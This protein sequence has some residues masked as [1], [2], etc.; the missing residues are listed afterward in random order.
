MGNYCCFGRLR[1][2][3]E[4]LES[5]E[6]QVL[7]TVASYAPIS[8]ALGLDEPENDIYRFDLAH[9]KGD[10]AEIVSLC[11]SSQAIDPF[12]CQ[13]HQW[14]E[15]PTTV[16]AL[17]ATQLAI[18]ASDEKNPEYKDAIR[19]ASGIPMLVKLLKSDEVDR[20]H[21]AIVAL[22]FLSVGNHE[23]CI[24]MYNAGAMPDLIRGM[25][26]SITGMSG[27]CAHTCRNIYQLGALL[28]FGFNN[29][30]LDMDYRRFFV[31][32]GGLKDLINLLSSSDDDDSETRATQLEAIYHLEDFI[33]DGVEEIPE[34][35]S[36]VKASGALSKL[37]LL[38]KSNDE[39]LRKA[40]K[41]MSV[42]LAD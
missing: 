17:A 13:I 22:A 34:F 35:V 19:K 1:E 2:Y 41:G 29:F 4:K 15:N 8:N 24:E 6:A 36:L 30:I 21:A 5:I 23:N 37:K 3:Q 18:Y 20:Y 7:D 40:A 32:C 28:Y 39:D 27:A 9:D 42:R 25:R 12:T 33:M 10:I 16:G 31:K 38:E 26:S 11:E 14:A